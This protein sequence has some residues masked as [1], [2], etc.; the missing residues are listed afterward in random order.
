[1]SSGGSARRCSAAV[2]PQRV[3]RPARLPE[4][5]SSW[6]AEVVDAGARTGWLHL[7]NRA[8][9]GVTRADLRAGLEAMTD[10]AGAALVAD[11][12]RVSRWETGRQQPPVEVTLGYERLLGLP[13]GRLL[14]PVRAL[15][16]ATGHPPTGVPDGAAEPLE[17]LLERALDGGAMDGGRWLRLA[18]ALAWH[19]RF[20][21]RAGDAEEM[22]ARLVSEVARTAGSA[23]HLRLEAALTLLQHPSSQRSVLRA[24]GAWLTDPDVQLV[25]PV[26]A[27]LG[28]IGGDTD[29][30]VVRL[31][32]GQD[33][34]VAEAT[35]PVAAAKLAAGQVGARH[36]GDLA[37]L[38]A[39]L[40][41]VLGGRALA[42][43][44][45][46]V[47]HLP[48]EHFDR[49][50][51]AQRDGGVRDQLMQIRGSSTLIPDAA[52]RRLARSLA[53]RAQWGAEDREPPEP[54]QMLERLVREALF[55]VDGRRRELAGRLV[56]ATPY[57]PVLAT[58]VVALTDDPREL[59]ATRA[60]ELVHV[61]GHGD[62]HRSVV[63]RAL[64]DTA[65]HR[66]EA[67]LALGLSDVPLTPREARA[68]AAVAAQSPDL[69]YA[70]TLALALASPDSL[71]ALR[72][73][74]AVTDRAL[75]W[76]HRAGP[77][78]VDPM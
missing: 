20:F 64:D 29:D 40:V 43:L 25:T 45:D 57:G 7:S 59:L 75:D 24:V 41:P 28:S 4:D 55:H 58:H 35:L 70:A 78:V 53:W 22:A 16:R 66:T 23:H 67:L 73:L 36:L 9:L 14:A 3:G 74:D 5:H 77:Q 26:V 18:M 13:A 37:D 56:A 60:W 48:R 52:H 42:D 15:Q 32:Q 10:H 63:T 71:P 61:L 33:S 46:L 49:V 1:M 12:S 21:L 27:L 50:V 47:C 54:D 2:D 30:L 72:G 65:P 17:G 69:R 68:V 8:V 31:L 51:R 76:W 19:D 6:D 38:A 39:Q 62:A 11:P 44:L 34:R